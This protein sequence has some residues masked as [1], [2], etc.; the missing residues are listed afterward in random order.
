MI[1]SIR[2]WNVFWEEG[3][4]KLNNS[5]E[6]SE[7]F[8]VSVVTDAKLSWMRVLALHWIGA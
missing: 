3:W 5:F 2:H 4:M 1:F 6:V 7:I 8:K